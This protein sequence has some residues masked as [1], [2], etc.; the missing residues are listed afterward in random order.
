VIGSMNSR[1]IIKTMPPVLE[2][3]GSTGEEN[4]SKH[5]SGGGAGLLGHKMVMQ[6]IIEMSFLVI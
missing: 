1:Q 6:Y 4:E 2:T 5:K 3:T